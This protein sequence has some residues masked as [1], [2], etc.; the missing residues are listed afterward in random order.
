MF[1]GCCFFFT[2]HCNFIRN[3]DGLA[4]STVHS[5]TF[6]FYACCMLRAGHLARHS[7]HHWMNKTSVVQTNIA[8]H[9]EHNSHTPAV[10]NRRL[11]IIPIMSSAIRASYKSFRHRQPASNTSSTFLHQNILSCLLSLKKVVYGTQTTNPFLLSITLKLSYY[12]PQ[13][14]PFTLLSQPSKPILFHPTH[15]YTLPRTTRIDTPAS[16][17]TR[18]PASVCQLTSETK[19]FFPLP[20]LA[21]AKA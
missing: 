8:L 4:F 6:F 14:T 10:H 21:R 18:R 20:N 11:S 12:V 7:E 3:L 5:I 9:G 15:T 19:F 1:G 17:Q 13:I 2:F 16:C